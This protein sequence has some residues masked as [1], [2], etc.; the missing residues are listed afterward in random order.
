MPNIDFLTDE[1]IRF[2]QVLAHKLKTQDTSCTRKPVYFN[3]Q[4]SETIFGMDRGYAEDCLLIGDEYDD[5]YT[6]EEA[7]E[8]LKKYYGFAD[9]ELDELYD[10]E[11]IQEFLDKQGIDN[12]LTGYRKELRCSGVFLTRDAANEHIEINGHNLKEPF[13]YCQHAFRNPEL[14]K[15]LEIIEKFDR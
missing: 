14:E 9:S 2:L 8:H 12:T 1:E 4:E 15:L 3:I 7:V 6:L 13:V 5:I 11:D 10:L